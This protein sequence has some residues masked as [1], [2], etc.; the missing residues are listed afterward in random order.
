MQNALLFGDRTN[1]VDGL[2]RLAQTLADNV[3]GLV[4][5][6]T[7]NDI[8]SHAGA[9]LV[10][11]RRNPALLPALIK[12]CQRTGQPLLNLGTGFE[13]ELPPELNFL[14]LECP[15]ISLEAIDFRTRV[16][17]ACA[18]MTEPFFLHLTEYHQRSK[19]DRSGTAVSMIDEVSVLPQS[20]NQQGFYRE[21]V[22]SV[23][24]VAQTRAQNYE[25]P[26]EHE[27]GFAIHEATILSADRK[28]ILADLET[29]EIYGRQTYA[30]GL[31]WVLQ[32]LQRIEPLTEQLSI[33]DFRERYM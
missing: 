11:T 23:R 24:S 12:H 15:N 31:T 3:E 14:Y 26:P 22:T 17:Q 33:T 2:G 4:P 8:G 9:P 20:T 21:A 6:S 1:P 27:N 29:L 5:V 25:V 7:L 30:E 16:Q 19:K 28:R 32:T 13:V 18:E 10:H